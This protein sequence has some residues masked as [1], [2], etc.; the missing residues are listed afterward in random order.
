[1]PSGSGVHSLEE[2]KTKLK[3][4]VS[5]APCIKIKISVFQ[6]LAK[7]QKDS[8]PEFCYDSIKHLDFFH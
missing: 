3:F 7:R 4:C 2:P 1:M 8:L 6:A 5:N